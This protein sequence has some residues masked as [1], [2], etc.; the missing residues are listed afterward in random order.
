MLGAAE[1]DAFGAERARHARVGRRLGVG[2]HLHAADLVGP[3]HDRGEIAREFRLLHR[4]GALQHLAVAAVDRDDVA[5]AEGDAHRHQRAGPVVDAQRA[6]ARNARL[7]HAAGDDRRVA[8]HAA[9]RG[10]DALRRMHAVD[11]FRARL[12]ADEDHLPAERLRLLGFMRGKDDL[13]GR[14]TRR[15]RQAD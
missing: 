14:R 2:A 10:Q 7:A 13:A 8:R 1:P 3:F 6:G 11:V 4:H 5:V 15:S 12:D 9:A